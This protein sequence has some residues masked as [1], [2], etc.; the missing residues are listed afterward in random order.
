MASILS[1]T[2]GQTTQDTWG[3]KSND[4]A[5][6]SMSMGAGV[7]TTAM[8]LKWPD[9]FEHVI[10]ADT[11]DEKTETYAYI[12]KYLKP[13]CAQHGITWHTVR[14]TK[15]DSLMHACISKKALPSMT[16]WCTGDFK[17]KPIHRKLRELGATS[18]KPAYVAVGIS[19]DESQRLS[20]NSFIDKP[21]YE[22]KIYPFIDYRMTRN[23]C[24]QIIKDHGW[25][26]PLKSGCD[27]CPFNPKK[28]IMRIKSENPKRYDQIVAMEKLA[29]RPLKGKY[30]LDT[31]SLL[32]DFTDENDVCDSGHCFV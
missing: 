7:Q 30:N 11:G 19:I 5:F 6:V 13:F 28:T 26:L 20:S 15:Y 29:S 2:R 9:K 32:S 31:S 24:Y 27:F 14:N 16:R 17:I 22:H 4:K 21:K 10:F 1:D 23:D 25:P 12:E 18:K 3:D 8:L